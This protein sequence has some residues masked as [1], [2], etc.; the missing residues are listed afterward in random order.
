ML[1]GR[2]DKRADCERLGIICA[3]AEGQLRVF[4]RGNFVV[5]MKT[6]AKET[7]LMGPRRKS[8]SGG[9][10]RVETQRFI[11]QIDRIARLRDCV[12][13]GMRK[14]TEEKVVGVE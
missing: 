11:Q 14:R 8:V 2:P 12:G 7:L 6:A 4:Q 1:D 10:T 3:E 13:V 5:I 9:V